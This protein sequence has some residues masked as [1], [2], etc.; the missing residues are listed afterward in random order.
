MIIFVV[1]S[2]I[3]IMLELETCTNRFL[4]HILLSWIDLGENIV[5]FGS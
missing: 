5:C 3:I 2:E 1:V 4:N